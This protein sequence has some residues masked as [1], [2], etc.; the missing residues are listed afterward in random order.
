MSHDGPFLTQRK[1]GGV[2]WRGYGLK[3]LARVPVQ[4]WACDRGRGHDVQALEAL[5]AELDP[6]LLDRRRERGL[7]PALSQS[8]CE[9]F[10]VSVLVGHSA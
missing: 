6:K 1:S 3:Q 8:R 2:S 5:G 7:R 10:N 9:T 4:L